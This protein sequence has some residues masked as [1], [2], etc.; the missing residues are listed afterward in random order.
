MTNKCECFALGALVAA[1]FLAVSLLPAAGQAPASPVKQVAQEE[2]DAL[3][4]RGLVEKVDA[5]G[6]VVQLSQGIAI[7]VA[8]RPQTP[9]YAATRIGVGDLREGAG[10]SI[11]TESAPGAGET[12]LAAEVLMQPDG[13][14]PRFV[15][16]GA[17]GV[18]KSIDRS[19]ERPI[20]VIALQDGAERRL[21]TAKET[22][23]WR[24]H[25][26][27]LENVTPGVSISVLVRRDESGDAH[28]Q[29]ALF[30]NPPPGSMLPL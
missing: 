28:A 19:Q 3:R 4:I 24:L 11:R 12:P 20:L 14:P 10:V 5:E 22:T 6:V 23:V 18:L 25:L 2:R 29:H 8:I 7:R 17:S 13:Q 9:V 27:A 16:G 15:I 1:G 30:G 26:A 21:A